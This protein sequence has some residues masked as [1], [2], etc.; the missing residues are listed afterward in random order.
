MSIHFKRFCAEPGGH[1][2]SLSTSL[3]SIRKRGLP[4]YPALQSGFLQKHPL[5]R[6]G[7][8][9]LHPGPVAL[10]VE[11]QTGAKG[12]AFYVTRSPPAELRFLASA[13]QLSDQPLSGFLSD[14]L[15][16]QTVSKSCPK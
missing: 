15:G 12:C 3:G 1:Y 5:D 9:P 16:P 13:L 4:E 8:P 7:M 6:L 11:Q 14:G 10:S 2:P